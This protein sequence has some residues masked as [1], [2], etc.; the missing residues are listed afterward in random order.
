MLVP[1]R[2]APILACLLL[3][4]ALAGHG[5]ARAQGDGTLTIGVSQFPPTFHPSIEPSV[6]QSYTH[7]MAWRPFTTYDADWRL[8]CMLCTEL[9]TLENGL[10]VLE[11]TPEGEEGIAVTYT[12]RPDA[13]WGDGTAVTTDDVLFTW[14]VGRHPQSAFANIELY[15]Q[16]YAVDIVDAK[17]FTLHFD[18]VTFTYNAINDFR[19]LPAH[20]ERPVFDRDPVA[21]PNRTLYNTD[22]TRPGL[23]FGPYRITEVE[24]GAYIVL[25]PNDT[26]YGEPP[27]FD[28]IIVR[29]IENTAAMEANLLSGSIDMIA[30]ENGVTI[31][32]ALA[33]ADRHGDD[34]Q[35]L[36]QPGLFYEH[37]DLNL[38]NPLLADRRIR[39][40]LLYALDRETMVDRLFDGRQPVAR[41]SVSPLDHAFAADARSYPHDPDR[42]AALFEDAG[43]TEMRNGIRHRADGTPLAFTLMTTAGNRTREL[44]QQVLQAQWRAAGVDIRLRNEPARV[45]F[46]GTVSRREFEAM[47]MFAWF[48]SPENVPRT[49]LH[50]DHIPTPENNWS[51]QNYTGFT[52]AAMDVLIE[53]TEEEL[54]VERRLELW[55]WIQR[56]YAE[57]LPALPLFHRANAYILPTWLEGVE[58]TGHQ[59]GTTLW[60]E[61]WRRA[62]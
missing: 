9:P 56:I 28:R 18:R 60:V 23:Y 50:S 36:F 54:D 32:Q 15:R 30:G 42:A 12:I 6:A 53:A 35:I 10:A 49:V 31:D 41:T 25:E 37:I 17:T 39:Q 61:H 24:S 11:E 29:T 5:P 3:L 1:A 16:I 45:F 26:W 33:F 52:N 47:A 40:G 14:E 55:R 57:E 38:D 2:L 20:L 4:A 43:F 34:Y 13:V 22:T 21:Y 51:G 58:P 8:I 7:H 62:D 59:Y 27:H 48:S 19:L 44:V 46:G